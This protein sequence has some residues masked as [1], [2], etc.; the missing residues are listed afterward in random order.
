MQLKQVT[1]K[2]V[3]EGIAN[4][5]G[6]FG[7]VA[8][9]RDEDGNWLAVFDNEASAHWEASIANQRDGN[10]GAT[11]GEIQVRDT[12]GTVYASRDASAYPTALTD[13]EAGLFQRAFATRGD[14]AAL[15]SLLQEA[16]PKA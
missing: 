12:N 2:E 5:E 14:G 4:P 10:Y 7:V 6:K 11:Y 9:I 16:L 8:K 13:E 1:L 3:L 15:A